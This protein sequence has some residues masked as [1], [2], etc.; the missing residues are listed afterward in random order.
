MSPAAKRA[1]RTGAARA[2][3]AKRSGAT[4]KRS[5]AKRSSPR[6]PAS[7]SR[8]E[9]KLRE[10]LD[11]LHR[12]EAVR[13]PHTTGMGFLQMWVSAYSV[14]VLKLGSEPDDG[15]EGRIL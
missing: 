15:V 12:W 13:G 11:G 4:T 3:T 7:T 6:S 10:A 8:S 9:A 5:T 2:N 14:G 1:R